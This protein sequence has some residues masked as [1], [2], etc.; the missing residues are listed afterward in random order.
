MQ[1]S[2][3]LINN[4]LLKVYFYFNDR[5]YSLRSKGA[6]WDY[7]STMIMFPF[8]ISLYFLHEHLNNKSLL[9]VGIPFVLVLFVVTNV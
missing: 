3:T 5:P 8:S 1:L 4:V 2:Y 6:L 7:I 9:L